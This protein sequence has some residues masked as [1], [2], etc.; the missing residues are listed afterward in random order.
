MDI[1]ESVTHSTNHIPLSISGDQ[2][3]I[4]EHEFQLWAERGVLIGA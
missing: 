1:A 3:A 2:V 4:S